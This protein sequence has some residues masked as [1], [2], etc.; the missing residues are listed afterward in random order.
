M[1]LD[2][3]MVALVDAKRP[4]LNVAALRVKNSHLAEQFDLHEGSTIARE[5]LGFEEP[6]A[7]LDALSAYCSLADFKRQGYQQDYTQLSAERVKDWGTCASVYEKYFYLE[8]I[9][10]SFE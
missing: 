5:E 10:L 6:T 4:A 2:L 7:E 3:G 1:G 9:N 8:K